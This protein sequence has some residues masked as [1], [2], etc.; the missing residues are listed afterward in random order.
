MSLYLRHNE[1]A[2]SSEDAWH[3]DYHYTTCE[4]WNDT[5][6]DDQTFDAAEYLLQEKL[7]ANGSTLGPDYGATQDFESA[8]NDECQ[9]KPLWILSQV[10]DDLDYG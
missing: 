4:E 3:K 5:M 6:T 1:S 10:A 9:A 8:L 7:S 2:P